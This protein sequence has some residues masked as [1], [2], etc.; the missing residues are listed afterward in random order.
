M[1]MAPR[2]AAPHF[3]PRAPISRPPV[4]VSTPPLLR[5]NVPLRP[6]VGSAPYSPV[7]AAGPR[8]QALHQPLGHRHAFRS[9]LPF[10]ILGGGGFYGGYYDP[11]DDD[12]SY[13]ENYPTYQP[14][15][16]VPVPVFRGP[17]IIERDQPESEERGQCR[18]QVQTVPGEHGGRHEITIVR[19]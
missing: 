2:M 13:H 6:F 5:P 15:Y 8:I 18:T 19:C 1:S 3:A 12:F 9:G 14:V 7:R 4:H 11:S 17:R 16:S 10:T